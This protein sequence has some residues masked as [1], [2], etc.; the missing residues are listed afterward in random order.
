MINNEFKNEDKVRLKA[1]WEDIPDEV[2]ILSQWDGRKGWIG[3][4]QEFG[5]F[6]YGNQI[7]KI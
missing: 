2:F 4:K 7:E 6:I 1:V 5:W 3:D